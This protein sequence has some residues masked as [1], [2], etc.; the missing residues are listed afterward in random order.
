MRYTRRPAHIRIFDNGTNDG[1]G[2][3]YGH[4]YA[5]PVRALG[6]RG[7]LAVGAASTDPRKSRLPILDLGFSRNT[8][9]KAPATVATQ[10]APQSAVE[11]PATV[12]TD[13]RVRVV[14]PIICFCS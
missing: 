14:D 1:A 8:Q 3:A 13:D 2:R 12:G 6:R 5:K 11:R 4:P 7:S 9:K 10:A